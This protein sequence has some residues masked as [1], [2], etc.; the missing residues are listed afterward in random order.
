MKT[1]FLLFVSLTL[2][3]C[4]LGFFGVTGNGNVITENR[5]LNDDFSIMNVST[6]I[7]VYITQGDKNDVTV[8][9]D[10]NL[11][12]IIITEIE[13]GKLKIYTEEGIWKAKAK[14]VHVTVKNLEELNATSGSDVYSTNE[15]TTKDFNVTATSGADVDITVN[16]ENVKSS[17]TSGSDLKISGVSVNHTSEAN[18]GASIDAYNLESKNAFAFVTSGADINIYASEKIEANANSGGDIDYKG[19]PK[20]TKKNS[21]SGGSISKE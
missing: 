13:N 21:N 15:I 20:Q 2:T 5:K 9:A 18:S 3:S 8:E 17:A 11:H 12:D 10:E 7:D 14:K 6:G 1:I 4:N 16:A 19:N